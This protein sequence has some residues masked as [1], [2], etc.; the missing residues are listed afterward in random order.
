MYF[1]LDS[2][3]RAHFKPESKRIRVG[4]VSISLQYTPGWDQSDG[5]VILE[6]RLQRSSHKKNM[7]SMIYALS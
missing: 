5:I 6:C 4:P 1:A 3:F 2:P 7:F